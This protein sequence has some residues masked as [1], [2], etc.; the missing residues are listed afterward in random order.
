MKAYYSI[1]RHERSLIMPEQKKQS[2]I[3]AQNKKAR[4]GFF[5]EDT[6]EAGI[7]LFGTEVKSLRAGAVNL[8]D[9][10]AVSTTESFLLL[11]ST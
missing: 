7:Q 6:Y 10:F 5:V 2:R 11:E 1:N 3:I 4:H 8:K 9:S